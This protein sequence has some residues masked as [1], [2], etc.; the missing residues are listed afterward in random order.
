M[1]MTVKE[2]PESVS[3]DESESKLHT[4]VEA[5]PEDIKAKYVD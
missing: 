5:L 1:M 2:E 3:E 4:R